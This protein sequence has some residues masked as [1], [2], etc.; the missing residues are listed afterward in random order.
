VD[1]DTNLIRLEKKQTKAKQA[2]MAPLYGE[3]LGWLDMAFTARDPEC[4][5]IVSWKGHGI[6]EVRT[7]WS[8][9][10]K[11]AGVPELLLHDLRRTAARNMIRAGVPEKQVMSIVGW[12]TRAMFDR[13]NIT[14]KRDIHGAGEKMTRYLAKK[15]K[16]ADERVAKE[17]VRTKVR[18]V[19]EDGRSGDSANQGRI[20]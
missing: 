15:A 4:P 5:F 10:R 20:Q 2:R 8:K 14:D 1:W 7:A 19:T 13:Y 3:L 6:T 11:R 12:K 16:L 17:K 18:T 9:A